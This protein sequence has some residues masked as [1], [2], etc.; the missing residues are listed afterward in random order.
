MTKR[1]IEER[2]AN[3]NVRSPEVPL[4][5]GSGVLPRLGDP[6]LESDI[7]FKSKAQKTENVSSD[8][9]PCTGAG[10][11]WLQCFS[12]HWAPPLSS[13]PN[14]PASTKV[15]REGDCLSFCL[16]QRNHLDI[17]KTSKL[18]HL[19]D[20]FKI[21]L[22]QNHSCDGIAELFISFPSAL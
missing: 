17:K 12:Q 10:P 15:W 22:P 18:C 5:W 4:Q 20:K 7:T 3:F 2:E 8:D 16:R 19:R 14:V 9:K 11:K 6:F 21:V 1:W 13:S